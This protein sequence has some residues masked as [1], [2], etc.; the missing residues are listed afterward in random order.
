[1]A[2]GA[3]Q[4]RRSNRRNLAKAARNVGTFGTQMGRLASEIHQARESG[5]G[6]HRSPVE[7]VLEGLTARRS[8]G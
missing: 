2:L 4:A 3:R 5:N 6:K 7:V 8:R 1:M